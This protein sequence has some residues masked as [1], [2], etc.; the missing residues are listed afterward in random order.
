MDNAAFPDGKSSS[1]WL[2]YVFSEGAGVETCSVHARFHA[3]TAPWF[4]MNKQTERFV[5]WFVRVFGCAPRACWDAATS[6][7]SPSCAAWL[8]P[9]HKQGSEGKNSLW[10]WGGGF[11]GGGRGP[12]TAQILHPRGA[13]TR[14]RA[15]S[16]TELSA[17]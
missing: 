4:P 3:Q 2:A 10:A 11:L 13:D 17:E 14:V 8:D 16:S 6:R 9:R 5:P 7:S 15:Y 1:H 12:V